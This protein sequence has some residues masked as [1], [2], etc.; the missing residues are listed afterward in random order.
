MKGLINTRIVL[1]LEHFQHNLLSDT[2]SFCFGFCNVICDVTEKWEWNCVWGSGAPYHQVHFN[3]NCLF[4]LALVVLKTFSLVLND[5]VSINWPTSRMLNGNKRI[6]LDQ[7]VYALYSPIG[8][9]GNNVS[10]D[11]ETGRICVDL[12]AVTHFVSIQLTKT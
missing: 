4:L 12:F 1:W 7:R 11:L 6:N 3:T 10:S 2:I 9:D 5:A 8:L